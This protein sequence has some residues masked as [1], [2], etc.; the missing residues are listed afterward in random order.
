MGRLLPVSK[1]R[2]ASTGRPWK[3][4]VRL[5]MRPGV[6]STVAVQDACTMGV[7]RAGFAATV[8]RTRAAAVAAARAGRDSC[9]AVDVGRRRTRLG[10]GSRQTAS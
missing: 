6:P 4:W 7:A 1:N 9:A 8:V 3:I 10:S 2:R 5:S